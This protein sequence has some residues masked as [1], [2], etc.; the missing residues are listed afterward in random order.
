MTF[1]K[2]NDNEVSYF[3]KSQKNFFKVIFQLR[4]KAKPI[5]TLLT[6]ENP[7]DKN[8]INCTIIF[9]FY[10]FKCWKLFYFIFLDIIK[11]YCFAFQY[12][13]HTIFSSHS[14]LRPPPHLLIVKIGISFSLL[15]PACKSLELW[16]FAAW[17][18]E[19][20]KLW[21]QTHRVAIKQGYRASQYLI[22]YLKWN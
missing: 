19:A 10:F 1:D 21:D 7:L 15:D 5:Q 8:W 12:P 2:H 17:D 6:A 20:L 14:S 11:V 18:F 13:T 16:S 4:A 22:S 9:R 3:K